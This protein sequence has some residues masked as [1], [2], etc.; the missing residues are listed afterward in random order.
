MVHVILRGVLMKGYTAAQSVSHSAVLVT[1]GT[2]VRN[3]PA[4]VW[5]TL[6]VYFQKKTCVQGYLFD[7]FIR[8]PPIFTRKSEQRG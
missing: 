3:V 4:C 7:L 2:C 6:N 8:Y 5:G 1:P